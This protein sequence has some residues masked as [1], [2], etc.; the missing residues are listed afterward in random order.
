MGHIQRGH[1]SE[2]KLAIPN[3]ELL[4]RASE[5]IEPI[6]SLKIKNS[7]ESRNLVEI[8]DSLLPRLISGELPIPE[9]MLAS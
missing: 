6:I 9:E 5:I 2:S 8:R 4:N 3:S 7:I 1:L